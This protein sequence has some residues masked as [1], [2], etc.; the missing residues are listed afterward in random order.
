VVALSLLARFD[1]CWNQI[2]IAPIDIGQQ[3]SDWVTAVHC[4]RREAAPDDFAQVVLAMISRPSR[5]NWDFQEVVNRAVVER[6]GRDGAASRIVEE[7][8]DGRALIQ[9]KIAS[10][11]TL[12]V[13]AGALDTEITQRCVE[14]LQ[15]KARR[16]VPR[17]G[18]DA[19]EGIGAL[20]LSESAG[21][22]YPS[23]SA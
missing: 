13:A 2:E 12:S 14:Q 23:L 4:Q 10:F 3:H 5:T 11:A 20:S 21:C 16:P 9:A 6:L 19:V 18:F 15:L 1:A 22:H 17:A 8:A 7:P